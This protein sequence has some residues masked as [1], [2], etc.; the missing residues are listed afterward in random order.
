[1]VLEQLTLN[2]LLTSVL[3]SL[4]PEFGLSSDSHWQKC[5]LGNGC[6]IWGLKADESLG[7]QVS[8]ILDLC[9]SCWHALTICEFCSVSFREYSLSNWPERE[10]QHSLCVHS[11]SFLNFFFLI[12]SDI[13]TFSR[14]CFV[15]GEICYKTMDPWWTF[16]KWC[17]CIQTA[18]DKAPKALHFAEEGW[19]SQGWAHAQ[20]GAM[21]FGPMAQTKPAHP[22]H[23]PP[24][25]MKVCASGRIW[26]QPSPLSSPCISKRVGSR[27]WELQFPALG[28]HPK[29]HM[30]QAWLRS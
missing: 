27:T 19:Q 16:T 6:C 21:V 26:H 9:I 7:Q 10:V 22:S 8:G 25:G 20:S 3:V 17:A 28:L 29:G 23:L 18:L 15:K 30:W 2:A 1:M 13:L 5:T 12:L 14:R 11:F 4:V 24:P